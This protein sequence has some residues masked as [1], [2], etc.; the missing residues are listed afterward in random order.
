[1]IT[2]K[3]KDDSKLTPEIREWLDETS[4]ILSDE[5]FHDVEYPTVY[6]SALYEELMKLQIQETLEERTMK[7]NKMKRKWER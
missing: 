1:M 5:V 6:S 7:A 2:L 4:K 3:L